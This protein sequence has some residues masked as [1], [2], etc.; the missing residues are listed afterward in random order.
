MKTFIRCLIISMLT[1]VATPA[2]SVE[3]LHAIQ[4]LQ[5]DELSDDKMEAISAEWLKAAKTVIG[6]ENLKLRLQFPIAAKM[7]EVDVVVIVI[8]PSFAEW[9]TFMDN[10]PGSA[11]EAI[12]DKYTDLID[13]GNGTLW[14]TVLFE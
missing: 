6:G 14:E 2:W 7:G 12:D 4:C 13:C 5:F 11:A 1:F 9:G 3:V 10:Y 8:A